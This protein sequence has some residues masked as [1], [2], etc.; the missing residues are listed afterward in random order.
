MK[1]ISIEDKILKI[2]KDKY[3]NKMNKENM[4]KDN[5]NLFKKYPHIFLLSC[6]IDSANSDTAWNT[7]KKIAL[8]TGY[9]FINFYNAVINKDTELDK[10]LA[11]VS[12][13]NN[14]KYFKLAVIKIKE[15]Y[16]SNAALIWK[17][18]KNCADVITK[19]LE[20]D[21]VGVKKATMTV[22]ILTRD[23]NIDLK[24]KSAIDISPD[25]HVKRS[26]CKLGLIKE[27]ETFNNKKDY[28]KIDNNIVI[29]KARSI[30]PEFPGIL[31]YAFWQI[32]KNKIC[33]N[34]MCKS[35]NDNRCP[36][37]TFCPQHKECN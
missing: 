4:N 18:A 32:G 16:N 6:I 3:S 20:F 26:M 34:N 22:N 17:N 33:E 23:F 28:Q 9:D 1:K 30:C 2:A 8:H 11:P 21:G 37:E 24:D 25:I 19:L 15:E 10:L 7:V 5:L 29:Y 35:N 27:P 36:F 13:R 31:D 12:S 14:H